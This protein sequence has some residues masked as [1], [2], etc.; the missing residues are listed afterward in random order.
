[1]KL[2]FLLLTTVTFASVPVI[3]LNLLKANG[4]T[5]PVILIGGEL[6]G[7]ILVLLLVYVFLRKDFQYILENC[8]SRR[9][10]LFCTIPVLYY[11]YAFAMTKYNFQQAIQPQGF[12]VR[13][14]PSMI[15]F[16]SYLLLVR[17]FRY[18]RETEQLQKEKELAHIQSEAA[19]LRLEELN[20][21]E[22]R[23]REYRHDM[24]HHFNLLLGLAEEGN[25]EKIEAYLRRSQENL[26]KFTPSRFCTNLTANLIFS[27]YDQKAKNLNLSLDIKA[28]LPETLPLPETELCSLLSNCLENAI[29]AASA[30][31]RADRSVSDESGNRRT[32][33]S[34]SDTA[35][36]VSVHP[37]SDEPLGSERT[38]NKGTGRAGGTED[39][40][41]R[42][43]HGSDQ[44]GAKPDR[45]SIRFTASVYEGKFLMMAENSY[46]GEVQM[47]DGI[48]YSAQKGHGY[49]T[50]NISAIAEAHG[51]NVMFSAENGIFTVRLVIPI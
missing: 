45:R 21:A 17:E 51:G 30:S 16:L 34:V 3:C 43:N 2:L 50:R 8:E 9:F 44:V 37:A 23:T 10:W 35:G 24:R 26:D 15:V 46:F 31:G 27:Y 6:T 22:E 20:L 29:T 39:W 4:C 49:G 33:R 41:R 36:A 38:D 19:K 48:P 18:T 12:W 7:A 32:D 40:E 28:S 11:I 5:N 14:I 1:M 42:R 25:L 47:K 13:H